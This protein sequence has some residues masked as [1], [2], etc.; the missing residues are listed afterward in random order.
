M[1]RI[2]ESLRCTLETNITLYVNYTGIKIKLKKRNRLI[3]LLIPNK[4]SSKAEVLRGMHWIQ[5][6]YFITYDGTWESDLMC[7]LSG[8]QSFHMKSKIRTL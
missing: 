8:P 4:N 5:N 7:N 3:H 2:V 1:C 6:A